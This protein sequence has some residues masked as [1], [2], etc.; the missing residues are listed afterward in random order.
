MRPANSF[1]TLML[2]GSAATAQTDP[3]KSHPA[4]GWSSVYL[5]LM[6]EPV[7]G[8]PGGPAPLD[9]WIS[10]ADANHDGSISMTEFVAD[11]GHFLDLL[12]VNKNGRVDAD[13]IDRYEQVVAPPSV[14]LAGGLRPPEFHET[15]SNSTAN[16]GPVPG[17]EDIDSPTGGGPGSRAQMMAG[18]PEP[19]ASADAD[20]NRSV[21]KEELQ[22]AAV[23]RF[24]ATDANGDHMLTRDELAGTAPKRRH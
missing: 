8:E 11:A 16:A 4:M 10:R 21:S 23:R 18:L 3:S 13:E 9:A 24:L 7:R 20:L 19:V 12:D 15:R 6:G 2:L 17:G 22:R 5:T 14:R 1:A